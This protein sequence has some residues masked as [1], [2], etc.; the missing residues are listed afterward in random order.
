VIFIDPLRRAAAKKNQK[1]SALHQIRQGMLQAIKSKTAVAFRLPILSVTG[2]LIKANN[3]WETMKIVATNP[4]WESF[5]PRAS[6][7]TEAKG[8]QRFMERPQRG[9]V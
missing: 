8:K 6:I 9:S 3:T 7:Y 5:I 1:P 4:T 2:P